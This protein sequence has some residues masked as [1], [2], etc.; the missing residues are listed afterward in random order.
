MSNHLEDLQEFLKLRNF[1]VPEIVLDGEI[2]RFDAEKP[3][4]GWYWGKMF[5]GDKLEHIAFTV[6]DWY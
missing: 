1:E 6:G 4:S 3:Y 5:K 2:H